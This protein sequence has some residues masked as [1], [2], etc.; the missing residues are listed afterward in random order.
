MADSNLNVRITADVVDLTTKFAIA[1]AQVQGLTAEMNQL[2]RASAK[3]L[4]DPAGAAR[5]QQVAGDMLHARGE[6]SALSSALAGA[7][8]TAGGF[9]NSLSG[10]NVHIATSAREVRRLFNELRAGSAGGAEVSLLRLSSHLLGLG[11]AAL[12]ALAGVGGLT[13]GLGYL[14][15]QAVE[16]GRA[17]DAANIGA[18]FAGNLELTGAKLKAFTDQLAASPGISTKAAQKIVEDL[19]RIPNLTAPALDAL[20]NEM[21]ALTAALAIAGDKGGEAVKKFLDPKVSA[22]H[23]AGELKAMGAQITRTQEEAAEAADK[24]GNAYAVQAAKIQLLTAATEKTATAQIE[25]TSRVTSS[26]ANYFGA[27]GLAEQG[28]NA[29]SEFVAANTKQWTEHTAAVSADIAA[30]Q[31]RKPT[32]EMNVAAGV[33]IAKKE[34]PLSEQIDAAR[35]KVEQLT[36]DLAAAKAIGSP[37]V[38]LLAN[39][40][41]TAQEKLNALQFGPV[42]ERMRTQMTQVAATWD[43]TQSGMLAKQREIASATLASVQGNAKEYL[44]VQQEVAR[45]DV[46]IRR[47]TGADLIANARRI[48]TEISGDESKSAAQRLTAERST[49]EALLSDARIVGNQKVQIAQEV[50]AKTAEI[51]KAEAA[52]TQ[53]IAR[54][55][56][57]TDIRIG[58]MQI[59]AAKQSLDEELQLHQIN[60]A[61]KL[62]I[63]T[64]LTT[65]E[66]QLD[67]QRLNDELAS[68]NPLTARY[69]EVY[70]Q[71]RELK[72][73][74]VLDLATLDR[75]GAADAAREAQKEATAWKAAIGEIEGAETTMLGDL[76][77]KR[78]SFGQSAIQA[79][80]QVVDKEIEDDVRAMTTRLLIKEAGLAKEK[81]LEQGGVLYHMISEHL[82]TGHTTAAQTAQSGAVLAGV[83]AR[84]AAQAAGAAT[85]QAAAVTAGIATIGTDAA[86]AAAGAAASVAAIPFVGWVM[87]PGVAAATYAETMGYTGLAALDVGAWNVPQDM[88]ARIHAGE[89]VVP[90]PYAEGMRAA[91]GGQQGGAG[92]GTTYGDFHQTNHIHQV[93]PS[94][95]VLLGHLKKAVRN[96]HPATMR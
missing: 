65:Q 74:L 36:T 43:G 13:A 26:W 15:Y 5:L 68:L 23:L 25:S 28:L 22:E 33:E 66:A 16:A 96:F 50:A 56:V 79:A 70:N 89:A 95:E 61:Q 10:A 46:E 12:L 64:N 75:Q 54:S 71:I 3:G 37:D 19:V 78:K 30:T 94:P 8:V 1:K 83:E 52:E 59:E 88:T 21:P 58:H 48:N 60:A 11:P 49:L 29:E 38:T 90:R 9:G 42:L 27:I 81:A 35:S 14:V 62:T 57:A 4:I 92:G 87:A 40:L 31:S 86:V 32:P 20:V 76:L 53:S 7:G 55:N 45:L 24:S 63:L 72:A 93:V 2:A 41:A 82:G 73:K 84:T 69:T 44:S 18:A 67:I 47:S 77:A 17:L 91:G 80:G 39:G 51:N 34:N 6:A 85:A